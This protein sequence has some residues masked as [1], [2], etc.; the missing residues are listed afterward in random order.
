MTILIVFL[1]LATIAGLLYWVW[2]WDNSVIKKFYWPAAIVKL[3]AGVAIGFIHYRYYIQSDTVFFFESARQLREVALHDM[4]GYLTILFSVPEGYF[5]GEHRTLLFVKLV[6]VTAL[7]TDGNYYLSSL[8]FSLISFLAAW[9]LA[10]WIAKLVPSMAVP[11]VVALLYFPSCV[12]WSSGIL[13]E[14]LAMAGIYYLAGLAIKAWLRSRL[15]LP[16]IL[17]MGLAL[18]IVWSLKYY[19]AMVLMPVVLGVL[20]TNRLAAKLQPSSFVKEGVIFSCIIVLLALTGGLLHPNLEPGKI[21]HVIYSTHQQSLANSNPD[22]VIQYSDL[23]STWGSILL[24]APR[25]LASGL[26]APVVPRLSNPFQQLAVVENLVLLVFT[27]FAFPYLRRI[28]AS[29]Y[30]LWV[31]AIV[32]YVAVLAVFISLCTPNIGTLVRYRVGFLPFFVLLISQQPIIQRLDRLL[33]VPR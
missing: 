25:A 6:S 30:R 4:P 15:S 1:N 7:L 3:L 9:N 29:P 33:V 10:R 14:S 11:A 31:V 20:L 5:Q 24:H 28:P 19:Y 26:F 17:L 23:S 2:R 12:F 22:N 32:V 13:K 16:D 27:V 8:Y 21:P 18:W